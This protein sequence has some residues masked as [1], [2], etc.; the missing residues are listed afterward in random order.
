VNSL[1]DSQIELVVMLQF[2]CNNILTVSFEFWTVFVAPHG[3]RGKLT[4]CCPSDLASQ[5]Y[6]RCVF[7]KSLL[8]SGV[9]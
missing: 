3:M 4:G 8:P 7:N 1:F 9:H 6:Q 2:L 5:L